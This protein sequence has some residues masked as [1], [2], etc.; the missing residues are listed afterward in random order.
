M[1]L[2]DWHYLREDWYSANAD[3]PIICT[4]VAVAYHEKSICLFCQP[5]RGQRERKNYV[6]HSTHSSYSRYPNFDKTNV[7]SGHWRGNG[8]RKVSHFRVHSNSEMYALQMRK[9][10]IS[11]A[12]SL[13]AFHATSSNDVT[14]I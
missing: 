11:P 5:N 14:C 10:L 8:L 1:I 7:T 12:W 9:A 3:K 13:H 6:S 4:F 2:T